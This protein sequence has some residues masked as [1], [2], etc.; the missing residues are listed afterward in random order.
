MALVYLGIGANLAPEQNISNGLQRLAQDVTLLRLSPCYRSPAIGFD[1]PDFINL[2]A[3]VRTDKSVGE[4]SASLK[5]LEQEFGR[6]PD[7]V[8]Y[9]SR[10]LDIDILM[11]DELT[12]VV[13][14]IELPRADIWRFAF[15][16]RPLLD[17]LPDGECPLHKQ[18]L[19]HYLPAVSSQA[20]SVCQGDW[21][22]LPDG[23]LKAD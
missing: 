4:L 6:S 12:G 5:A 21:L 20:L 9:S 15:V 1:G 22:V 7:A 2:V 17:L 13:D 3:E 19:T 10:A 18:P 11:V 8:K 23:L 14:S 16:L